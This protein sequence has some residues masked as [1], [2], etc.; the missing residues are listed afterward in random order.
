MRIGTFNIQHGRHHALYL[1]NG[2]EVID[3]AGV[4]EVIRHGELDFCG[5]NE[6]RNQESVEGLCNQAKVI[7]EALG[8]HY[9]FA[10]AID[11]RGGEY[12]NALVS[13]HPIV[14][15]YTVPV[16]VS[17]ERR[18]AQTAH[19]YED[20]VLLVAKVDTPA[21]PVTVLV[22]HFGLNPDEIEEAIEC[23]EG[24]LRRHTGHV[25]LMGD[26][27]LTP[28]SPYYGRLSALLRDTAVPSDM[29]LT[30]PS[31]AP[32]IKIDYVFVSD[33]LGAGDVTVPAL[34]QSDHRPYFVTLTSL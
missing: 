22:T 2:C 29:P 11:Y 30:F 25:V 1:E 26:F 7:A 14:D 13:R 34:T 12:G 32:K 18:E 8:Y 21:A 17:T 16:S 4:A 5:L 33:S 9:V 31:H 3:L 19:K 27:N 15:W 28:D 6:V 20:R 10:K 23:I 24:E